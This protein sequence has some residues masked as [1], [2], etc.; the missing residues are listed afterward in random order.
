MGLGELVQELEEHFDPGASGSVQTDGPTAASDGVSAAHPEGPAGTAL[1]DS[2]GLAILVTCDYEENGALTTLLGTRE[3]ARKM[4]KT[5]NR[6]NYTTRQLRNPT[7]TDVKALVKEVS[8]EL[9]TYNMDK[10]EGREKVIIFAFSGHGCSKRKIEHLYT[11]D[12]KTLQF[13][14]EIVFPLTRHEAVKHVPK[15][16]FIDACRGGEIITKRVAAAPD[17]QVA[18]SGKVYFHP[19]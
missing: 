2:P 19:R 6:F 4:M 5:F 18:K 9:V 8:N 13:N 17:D 3:D 14:D 7:K 11:N 12:G 15:L 10:K 1:T 16:F